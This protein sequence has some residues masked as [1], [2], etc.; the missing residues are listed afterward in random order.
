MEVKTIKIE[1]I[2]TGIND[3]RAEY[4][5]ESMNDLI[6]SV[7]RL[8]L[9]NPITVRKDNEK[10]IVVAGHRRTYA[11]RKAG[12]KEIPVVITD[13]DDRDI[14]EIAFA[15]N[16][17]RS[18]LTPLEL[19]YGMAELI[20]KDTMSIEQ[21]A[22]SFG[23]SISW[24]KM[25]LSILTW[26]EDV[27]ATV[28]QGLLNF[29]TAQNLAFVE[30]NQYRDF[31]IRNAIENGATARTTAAWLQAWKAN[32]TPEEAVETEP[33][34]VDNSTPPVLPVA[35]CIGCGTINRSDGMCMVLL[36]TNCVNSIRNAQTKF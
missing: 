6:V 29:S 11:C 4:D 33:Q 17:F 34:K 25:Q 30:D 16:L 22:R 18:D 5:D 9:I 8:G 28:H 12:L 15:E 14:K 32:L 1:E 35:P 19:A 31:L 10:Y 3:L 2:E 27:Q 24:V 36:C 26:P 23:K 20:Q 21:I 13:K 7:K